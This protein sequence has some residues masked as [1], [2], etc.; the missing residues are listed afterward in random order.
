MPHKHRPKRLIRDWLA[1]E[2]EHA[3]QKWG[4]LEAMQAANNRLDAGI[5]ERQEE[6][7][8][9]E[10]TPQIALVRIRRSRRY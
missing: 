5:K 9:Q 3:L 10:I 8:H 6:A 7:L 2:R 4:S 1:A